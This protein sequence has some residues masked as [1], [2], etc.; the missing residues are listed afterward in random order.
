MKTNSRFSRNVYVMTKYDVT[1]ISNTQPRKYDNNVI[2]LYDEYEY[3]WTLWRL[4]HQSH[5]S[6]YIHIYIYIS[7]QHVLQ[8]Q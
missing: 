2:Y 7:N 8:Y 6:I 1:N 5:S 4:G 3:D